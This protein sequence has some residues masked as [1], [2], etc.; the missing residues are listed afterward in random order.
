MV[1]IRGLTMEKTQSMITSNDD[2]VMSL[3]YVVQPM[4]PCVLCDG[5]PLQAWGEQCFSRVVG[6]FGTFVS[7]DIEIANL[8]RLGRA[9]I[10]LKVSFFLPISS[11]HDVK[12]IGKCFM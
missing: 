6:L 2:D 4:E 11:C 5:I 10:M 3:L 12:V 1:L 7:L 9:Q 8:E